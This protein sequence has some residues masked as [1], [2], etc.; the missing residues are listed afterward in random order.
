MSRLAFSLAL[1]CLLAGLQSCVTKRQYD[2]VKSERDVFEA[3]SK[4][5]DT[6]QKQYDLLYEVN[7]QLEALYK[8]SSRDVEEMKSTN[9]SLYNS[10]IGLRNDTQ[11]LIDNNKDVLKSSSYQ[12]I[13][14]EE[15]LSSNE[16]ELD[17][18]IREMEDISSRVSEADQI[19]SGYN[20]EVSQIRGELY[21]KEARIQELERLL[22][23]QENQM[24]VLYDRL[25]SS[26][27]NFGSD[28]L[29]IEERDG[30]IYVSLSQQLLFETN[31]STV[32]RKG[33]SALQQLS[34]VLNLSENRDIEI[35]V[36]GHTDTQGTANY[37]WDL[38]VE[39][40]TS[41]V[42]VLTSYGVTPRRITAAGRGYYD[43]VDD[44]NSSIGRSR[45]R[46]TEIILAPDLDGIY[47][48][49]N[50]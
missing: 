12:K 6:L 41:V 43:P 3:D 38:S 32:D 30:K 8:E 46:R 48:I 17:R 13:R 5:L 28:E 20:E 16:Y 42:K 35:V 40:A 36:E 50:R 26:L 27:R 33:R 11:E 49:I 34:Q 24:S 31:K 9:K 18:R 39:R 45:N 2:Y 47:R 25:V 7:Q 4:K 22:N 10:Y 21:N 1:V 15:R 37:N 44:N 14:L 19:L 29:T 23:L